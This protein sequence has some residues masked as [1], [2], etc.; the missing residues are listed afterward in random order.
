[1]RRSACYVSEDTIQLEQEKIVTSQQPH[2]SEQY[3]PV[4][5]PTPL[6]SEIN[7]NVLFPGDLGYDESRSIWN[8][9]IDRKPAMIVQ[10]R[11][12]S[13]VV[14]AVN[15][16][17]NNGLSPSIKGGGHNIAGMAVCDDGLMIDCSLM[18]NVSLDESSRRVRVQPG[19]V[20][21]DVDQ[22]TQAYGLAVPSGI[23]STT[24]VAGLTLGGG[25]G[26]M[27][28]KWGHT[29]D[30]LR[31]VEIVTADGNVH[32]ASAEQNQDL[33]WAVRGG[34]GN[35]GVVTEFE[36]EPREI[37][38]TIT[39]GLIL[40]P[41]DEAHSVIQFF[42]EFTQTTPHELTCLLV[43]RI[44]PPAPFLPENVHG[45]PVAGIAA[46]YAGD[47]AE[48]EQ[49]LAPL[50]AFGDPLADTIVQKPY[51]THQS[52]LDSG[53]PRGRR[54]YWKSE[55]LPAVPEEVG[56][57]MVEHCRNFTS[58]HSSM[59]AMQLGGAAHQ[60][61]DGGAVSHKSAEYVVA[62]QSAWDDPQTDSTHI[63]WARQFHSAIR[64]YS[65]GG[66]YVNFLTE[67]EG[68]ER[69]YEAYEPEI[70]RQLATIKAKYDPTNLFRNNKNIAP[71]R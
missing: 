20:W 18:K 53:Q 30:H 61:M 26:W 11:D 66:T 43:L 24:G 22:V 5:T 70:Y 8:A 49:K 60:T 6:T 65:T 16:A 50:K 39:G 33:F 10:P 42:R 25:F 14:T 62:I 38:P 9:M 63:D 54:Y 2:S 45:K 67:E 51:V 15:Y 19:A 40:Y 46:L 69:I 48:G 37:G 36:F 32:R 13:D 64:P 44:A 21:G 17:R 47:P 23:I 28:R 52:F 35:F 58:P 12:I 27:T 68:Q 55:Y 1:M 31:S 71:A 29:A 7:G 59:L 34:G 57:V 4:T 56:D 3:L 41:F